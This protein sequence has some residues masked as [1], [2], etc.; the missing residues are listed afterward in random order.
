MEDFSVGVFAFLKTLFV[1]LT[2]FNDS[3]FDR[4]R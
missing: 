3:V 4:V 2:D 1:F